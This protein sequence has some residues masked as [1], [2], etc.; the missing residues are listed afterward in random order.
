MHNYLEPEAI[1]LK[2]IYS[3]TYMNYLQQTH[4]EKDTSAVGLMK[5]VSQND[6]TC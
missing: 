4:A 5:N 1:Q 6:D 3:N 2:L